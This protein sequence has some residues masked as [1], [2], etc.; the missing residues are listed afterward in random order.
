MLHLFSRSSG[1]A[2]L[3]RI[4]LIGSRLKWM[5]VRDVNLLAPFF[6]IILLDLWREENFDL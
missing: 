4:E 2:K 6:R 5:K 1:I 3:F